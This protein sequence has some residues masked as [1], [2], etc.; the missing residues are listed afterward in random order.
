MQFDLV[1]I[2]LAGTASAFGLAFASAVS[3]GFR[4][5][6]LLSASSHQPCLGSLAAAGFVFLL[7]GKI[8]LLGNASGLT[9][10]GFLGFGR[11]FYFLLG[12]GGCWKLDRISGAH[13][14]LRNKFSGSRSALQVFLETISR[15]RYCKA[16]L[17]LGS[18][19]SFGFGSFLSWCEAFVWR[20]QRTNR[21][22]NRET[23]VCFHMHI[24]SHVY[25]KTKQAGTS[26][27]CL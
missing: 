5:H 9:A 25:M 7:S 16:S 18:I 19:M 15:N 23:F 24:V 1:S 27:K 20:N 26:R 3:I 13:P 10:S 22:H 12:L 14:F 4:V 2:F 6:L 8:W 21:T 17:V 11:F